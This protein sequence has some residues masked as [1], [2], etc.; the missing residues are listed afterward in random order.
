[1]DNDFWVNITKPGLFYVVEKWR[2]G[3]DRILYVE[4]RKTLTLWGAQKYSKRCIINHIY[5]QYIK[6]KT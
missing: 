2:V 5:S 3:E 1:M 6:E 4:K